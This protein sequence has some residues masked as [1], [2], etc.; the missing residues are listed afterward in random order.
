MNIYNECVQLDVKRRTN[1]P[2]LCPCAL[3][4]TYKLYSLYMHTY[5]LYSLYMHTYKLYSLYMHIYKL[6]SL[7]MYTL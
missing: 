5:K 6:Y 2:I 4:R 7:H 1:H 3:S